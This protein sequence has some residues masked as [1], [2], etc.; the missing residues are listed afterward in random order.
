MNLKKLKVSD[1]KK[2][3]EERN[4]KNANKLKKDELIESIQSADESTIS[5]DDLIDS[6]NF[7]IEDDTPKVKTKKE[8]KKK[9]IE[10]SSE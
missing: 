5:N 6:M 3:A 10:P 2:M 7:D 4:V 9:E 8:T 1:L